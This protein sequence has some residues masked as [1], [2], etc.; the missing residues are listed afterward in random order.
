VIR[1]IT[2]GTWSMGCWNASPH[3]KKFKNEEE[4]V[5]KPKLEIK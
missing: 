3:E 5:K 2:I 1:T 4:E